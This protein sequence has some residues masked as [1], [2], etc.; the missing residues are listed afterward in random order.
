MF[1]TSAWP[2][3]CAAQGGEDLRLDQRIQQLFGVMNTVFAS[4][5][6]TAQ[7]GPRIGTYAV[8]PMTGKVGMIE[9]VCNT[10]PIKVRRRDCQRASAHHS[11]GVQRDF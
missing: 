2:A 8:I 1:F 3:C 6:A 11:G 9:W 5:P 4:A 10:V 7:R